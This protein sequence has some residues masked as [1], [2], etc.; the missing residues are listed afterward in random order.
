MDLLTLRSS[1]SP[2]LR[3]ARFAAGR[4]FV[5]AV[6]KWALANDREWRYA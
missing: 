2:K 3:R 6:M 5:A 4:S 1:F